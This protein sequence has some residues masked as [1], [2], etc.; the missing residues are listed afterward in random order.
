MARSSEKYEMQIA[1]YCTYFMMFC[2]R[3]LALCAITQN[4][5]FLGF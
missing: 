4:V 1:I 3:T 5:S 2:A